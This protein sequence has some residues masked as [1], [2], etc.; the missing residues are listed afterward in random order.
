MELPNLQPDAS[1]QGVHALVAP[2]H[3]AAAHSSVQAYVTAT[4]AQVQHPEVVI[5]P[6]GVDPELFHPAGKVTCHKH[7]S[8]P[9]TVRTSSTHSAGTATVTAT[10]RGAA[11]AAADA[12]AATDSNGDSRRTTAA[13]A[14]VA[15]ECNSACSV[16]GFVARLAPEKSCGLFLM[17]A[18]IVHKAA[19]F[20]RY[21][22]YA[23]YVIAVLL[24]C[25]VH[26]CSGQRTLRCEALYHT[27]QC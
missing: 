13:A 14:V 27:A 23:A 12:A 20:T 22:Y 5:I 17:V 16:V 3:Y 9:A 15:N 24:H 26:L 10:A 4:S 19:P 1:I 8:A 2:S 7:C 6:P 18:A 25:N 21:H 11:T